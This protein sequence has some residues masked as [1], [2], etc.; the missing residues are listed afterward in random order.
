MLPMLDEIRAAAGMVY[1]AL[2]RETE[3]VGMYWN[4]RLAN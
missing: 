4:T 3:Y 2:W 1:A